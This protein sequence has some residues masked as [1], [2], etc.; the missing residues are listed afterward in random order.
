[1]ELIHKETYTTNMYDSDAFGN[2]RISR[3]TERLLVSAN[4]HAEELGWGREFLKSNNAALVLVRLH[5]KVFKN[6]KI[7]EN[8]EISTWP[9]QRVYPVTYRYF[10]ADD[11]ETGERVW[12]GGVECALMDLCSRTVVNGEKFGLKNPE[13]TGDLPELTSGFAR[14][15]RRDRAEILEE[16]PQIECEILPKYS[17]LDYN[18]HVNS[19]RYPEFF[20]NALGKTFFEN[21]SI[22][23]FDLQYS[24]EIRPDDVITLKIFEKNGDYICLG[25]CGDTVK[26]E[27]IA[28][29]KN[30]I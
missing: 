27:A 21:N 8:I 11:K 15:N 30:P 9:L 12:E 10:V 5:V 6:V 18:M 19:A 3:I 4:V 7:G 25:T 23:E 13:L 17:Y 29:T 16:T 14:L 24:E 22:T 26:F 28:K 2:P 20:E 1:M